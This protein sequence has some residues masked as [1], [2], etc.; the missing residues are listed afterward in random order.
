MPGD[1]PRTRLETGMANHNGFTL[2]EIAAVLVIIAILSTLAVKHMGSSGISVY[3]DA[4]RL[5]ADLR[6]AQS[7]AMARAPDEGGDYDGEVTVITTDTGWKLDNEGKTDKLWFADGA[8]ED[9]EIEEGTMITPDV[10]I[11]FKYPKGKVVNAASDP[12]T[13]TLQRG[14]NSIIINVYSE[15]GYVEIQ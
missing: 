9:W 1:I 15:T 2:I 7:L 13:I 6:Y 12:T 14:D 8:R 4:D 3:G 5:V 11:T 10:S